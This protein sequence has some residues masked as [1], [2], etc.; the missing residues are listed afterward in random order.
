MYANANDGHFMP[1]YVREGMWMLKLRSYYTNADKVRL[2]PKASSIL[3]STLPDWKTTPFT[4]WGAYGEGLYLKNSSY[5]NGIPFFGA[6]GLYGSY[7]INSWLC[8]VPDANEPTVADRASYWRTI[9]V[10]APSTIPAFGD[11]VWE[12]TKAKAT[13]MP[14]STRN[15]GY[16]SVRD[17]LYGYCIPR[18]GVNVNWVFL[19]CSARKIPIKELWNLKWSRTFK[20]GANIPWKDYP[21]AWGQ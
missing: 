21:Y 20:I 1:G 6:K 10:A 2:C 14:S 16:S 11:S 19:D 4:A 12:G 15:P 3:V 8:D 9:N 13:D 17:G 7:G 18:H 5:P